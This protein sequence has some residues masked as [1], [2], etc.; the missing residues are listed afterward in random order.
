MSLHSDAVWQFS[1]SAPR[2][3]FACACFVTFNRRPQNAGDHV[4]DKRKGDP[5]TLCLH[6]QMK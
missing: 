4:A 6:P 1:D 2:A 5:F 3:F